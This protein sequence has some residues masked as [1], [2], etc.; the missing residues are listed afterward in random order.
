LAAF[1][2]SGPGHVAW[3]NHG[4]T[5]PE[6][7]DRLIGQA[8]M[9]PVVVVMPDCYT[10][11][12]GNQYVNSASIGNYADYLVKELVPFVAV[13]LNV[14]NSASGRGVFGKS[15]GG[16]GALYHA[17]H[18]PQ[19]WGAAASHAGDVG[20]DLVFR[21]TF[22]DTCLTLE[23]FGGDVRKFVQYFW[24]SERPSGADF[25]TLMILAMAA[26]YDPDPENPQH[27]RLPFDLQ[28]CTLDGERWQRWL[29]FDP[30]A[31]VSKHAGILRQLRG[32]FID[33]GSQDQYN[34]Q[35]G[36]RK[37]IKSLQELGIPGHFEEFQG[38]HSGIDWR[39]D[40]SLP[41]LAKS[42]KSGITA[43]K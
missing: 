26:S 28:T 4:E 22:P 20:F 33:V 2:N 17:M 3:R 5:L 37:L 7:L 38:S 1:T 12:G 13:E 39:L 40:K 34:I 42:L 21:S 43:A 9:P 30:L 15:S 6:R 31:M 41:F 36:T 27:I 35:F 10:S 32:L 16:Y 14:I 29:D 23:R 18:F 19:T 8:L 24:E 11:L 25:N